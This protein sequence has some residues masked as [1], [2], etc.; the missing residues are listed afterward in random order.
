MSWTE[1]MT[2]GGLVEQFVSS[3]GRCLRK[4]TRTKDRPC[5][6]VRIWLESAAWSRPP[7]AVTICDLISNRSLLRPSTAHALS[8][9]KDAF[10]T[11][12]KIN[13]QVWSKHRQ[14][15]F[16]S[17]TFSIVSSFTGPAIWL[18]LAPQRVCLWKT[19]QT[20]LRFPSSH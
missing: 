1:H 13:R 5:L 12:C 19:V 14:P 2:L 18:L 6:A 4:A 20:I 17:V 3:N 10:C 7:S 16:S 9:L 11:C 15:R 8:R